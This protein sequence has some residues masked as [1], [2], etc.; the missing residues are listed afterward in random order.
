MTQDSDIELGDH[1]A[2]NIGTS[3]PI[4][5][6]RR[7]I[8][9]HIDYKSIEVIRI[10]LIRWQLRLIIWSSNERRLG[11]SS[12]DVSKK[13]ASDFTPHANQHGLIKKYQNL[14]Y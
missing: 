9:S 11:S 12:P 6:C 1:K 14:K 2:S 4:T 10:S 13:S 5:S 7:W 3:N 8:R